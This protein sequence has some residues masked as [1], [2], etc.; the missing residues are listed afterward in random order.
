MGQASLNYIMATQEIKDKLDKAWF[1]YLV[2]G[3]VYT[4]RGIRNGDPFYEV[5]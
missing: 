5:L 3:E 4:H 2:S 1:H